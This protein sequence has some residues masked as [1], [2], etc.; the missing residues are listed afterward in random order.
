M[1]GKY[2]IYKGCWEMG[3]KGFIY[4]WSISDK[5]ETHLF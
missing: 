2:H 1:R 4:R 3:I 5:E